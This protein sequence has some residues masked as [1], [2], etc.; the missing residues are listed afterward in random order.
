M[1]SILPHVNPN[2]TGPDVILVGAGIMSATLGV[3]LKEI[4]PALTIAM[5][6]TLHDCAQESSNGWNN[7]GTG[8]S[9]F[10]ELNY[11]PQKADG[12]IDISKAV[13]IAEQ[14][15]EVCVSRFGP[16][17]KCPLSDT[18]EDRLAALDVRG[19]AGGNDEQ[20]A[21]LGGIRIPE[22][23]RSYVPLPVPRMLVRHG[24]R[25]RRANCAH[26]QVD[27]AGHETR[28]QTVEI[29]IAVAEHDFAYGIIV[30]QHA[31]DD[32]TV[33]QIADI[34]RRIETERLEFTELIRAADI[35]DHPSSGGGEI[36]GH[37]PSHVAKT[38]KADFSQRRPSGGSRVCAAGVRE[39]RNFGCTYGDGWSASFVLGHQGS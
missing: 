16:D 24:R 11:T 29:V 18:V 17:H 31:D 38:D 36:R 37:R 39:G 5:F 32:V 6:E 33:E 12:S 27:R 14:F 2:A 34:R 23:R 4:E 22:H 35:C 20:L 7:A 3:L 15:E 26:R 28:G 1:N 21:R 19:D 9:A 8:H 13:K 30:R 25:G 10:C